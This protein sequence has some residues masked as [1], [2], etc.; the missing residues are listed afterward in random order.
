MR[1]HYDL[2]IRNAVIVDG[3]RRPRFAG[4]IGVRAGRI[5]DI[6]QLQHARADHEIDA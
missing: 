5:A 3:T 6:G 1:L 4:D 2:L